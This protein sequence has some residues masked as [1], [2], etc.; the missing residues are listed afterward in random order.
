MTRYMAAIIIVALLSVTWG[1][2][3]QTVFPKPQWFQIGPPEIDEPANEGI[4]ALSSGMANVILALNSGRKSPPID[5]ELA[6]EAIAR[7][8][9]ALPYLE[10]ARKKIGNHSRPI[11][12][13]ILREAGY[14]KAFDNLIDTLKRSGYEPITDAVS[15]IGLIIRVDYDLISDLAVLTKK[16]AATQNDLVRAFVG[17]IDRKVILEQLGATSGA[18]TISMQ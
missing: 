18:I 4:D 7:L 5:V 2:Y 1:T 9:A 10:T 15:L 13:E 14:E 8:K 11:R 3:S 12:T 16:P 6:H 17:V